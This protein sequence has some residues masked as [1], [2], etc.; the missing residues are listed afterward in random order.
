MEANT[1]SST[2]LLLPS[3]ASYACSLSYIDNKL[4]SFRSYLRWMC[5]NQF[6]A[7]HTMIS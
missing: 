1:S 5:I 4:R 2:K 6:D 3:R 7:R